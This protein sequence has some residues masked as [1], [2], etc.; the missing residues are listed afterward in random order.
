MQASVRRVQENQTRFRI[1]EFPERRFTRNDLMKRCTS[2]EGI[3]F[4]VELLL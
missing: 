2:H 1:H 3:T 4:F